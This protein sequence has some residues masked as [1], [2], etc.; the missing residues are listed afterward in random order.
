MSIA[1]EQAAQKGGGK[2]DAPKEGQT[3][4]G[5][6]KE[7]A[8]PRVQEIRKQIDEL[9]KQRGAQVSKARECQRRLSYKVSEQEAIGKLVE[10]E[11]KKPKEDSIGKLKKARHMLEFKISTESLSLQQEK[12]LIRQISDINSKLDKA[13]KLVRLERKKV[14][15]SKDIEQYTGELQGAAKAVE[16]LDAKLDELY[17]SVRRILGVSKFK[18]RQQKPRERSQQRPPQQDINLEDIVVIKKKESKPQPAQ[19]G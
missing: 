8:D 15:I 1:K 6:I 19:Q 7:S 18:S 13:L 3:L 10:M 11:R 17:G 14:L 5:L 12:V 2:A 9:K 16:E 4:S